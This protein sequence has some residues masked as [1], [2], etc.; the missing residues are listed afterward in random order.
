M[1]V[2][3]RT[4]ESVK[5]ERSTFRVGVN[6]AGNTFVCE[7]ELVPGVIPFRC[8]RRVQVV[9]GSTV[10][11]TVEGHG[12]LLLRGEYVAG[13]AFIGVAE[14]CACV[15]VLSAASRVEMVG[16]ASME[17]AVERY[18][19]GRVPACESYLSLMTV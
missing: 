11:Q 4:V 5:R 14:V 1:V 16:V 2:S 10:V 6:E 8:I 7:S 15:A 13:N 9:R 12:V 19:V 17:G 18:G 3:S